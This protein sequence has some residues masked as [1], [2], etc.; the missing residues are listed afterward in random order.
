MKRIFF[1]SWNKKVFRDLLD[2][3]VDFKQD[4]YSSSKKGVLRGLHY[5][6]APHDQGKLIR[7]TKAKFLT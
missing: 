1:E 2:Y 3:D 7:C 6:I 4:N 5:Q